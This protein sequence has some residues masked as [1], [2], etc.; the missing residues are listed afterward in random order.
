MPRLQLWNKNK[1]L[2]YKYVDGIIRQTYTI[3]GTA[4]YVHKYLGPI[5][6]GPDGPEHPEWEGPAI[7]AKDDESQPNYAATQ[8]Q[9]NITNIQDLFYL[10]NR[11]RKYDE[12]VYELRGHYQ[13]SDTDFDLKQFGMFLSTDQIYI[14]FHLN[15]MVERIG[16]AIVAGDVLELLHLR[17]EQ[18]DPDDPWVNKFYV[19]ED[20]ARAAEGYDPFWRDHIWRLRCGPVQNQQE[21]YE[22]LQKDAKNAYD[23]S[24]GRSLEDVI[25][26][27]GRDL[28]IMESVDE[29]AERQVPKRKFYHDHLY[30]MPCLD[31]NGNPVPRDNFD[32]PIILAYGDG[33][34]PNGATLVGQGTSFPTPAQEGDFFLRTDYKPNVLFKRTGNVWRREEVDW[35][36]RWSAAN[37]VLRRFINKTGEMKYQDTNIELPHR[38]Y[39]SRVLK[40]DIE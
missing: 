8:G 39:L 25:S 21:F 34:P 35:R 7:K 32:R 31:I 6:S 12:N 5:E 4:V 24:I 18:L 3:G 10:E 17:E 36:S 16:R 22:L 23:E 40:P 15:D 20:A 27:Y 19:V 26:T 28:A 37:D 29:E 30:I 2:N 9:S 38:Q 33:K 13:I 11:D 14:T 1:G